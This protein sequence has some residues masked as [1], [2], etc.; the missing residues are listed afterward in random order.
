MFNLIRKKWPLM[1]FNIS[2]LLNIKNTRNIKN[3]RSWGRLLRFKFYLPHLIIVWHWTNLVSFSK[4]QFFLLG[5]W[6]QQDRSHQSRTFL[7]ETKDC[8]H[9]TSKIYKMFTVLEHKRR[10]TNIYWF[11]T[12]FLLSDICEMLNIQQKTVRLH[13]VKYLI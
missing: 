12:V 7:E 3:K 6:G 11:L 4:P 1:E 9:L 13:E 8:F 2:R 10:K 5:K